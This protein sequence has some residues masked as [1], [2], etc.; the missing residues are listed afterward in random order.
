MGTWASLPELKR[1]ER[2]V[3]H[4]PACSSADK[5][6]SSSTSA[7]LYAFMAWSGTASGGMVTYHC[8]EIL[9]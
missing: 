5:G 3:D 7:T 6:K 8:L 9:M 4:L 2:E 1:P